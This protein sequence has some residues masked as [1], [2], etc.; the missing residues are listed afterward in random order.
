M[1]GSGTLELRN[2]QRC[3]EMEASS[4]SAL[5]LE[6]VRDNTIVVETSRLYDLT[7]S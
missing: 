4:N 3:E 6:L 1:T 5:L 2:K 7:S